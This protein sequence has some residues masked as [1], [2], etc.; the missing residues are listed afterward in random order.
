MS[1]FLSVSMHKAG[2]GIFL[3]SLDSQVVSTVAYFAWCLLELLN[4]GT[5]LKVAVALHSHLLCHYLNN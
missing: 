2:D 3:K 4:I 5:G 1:V